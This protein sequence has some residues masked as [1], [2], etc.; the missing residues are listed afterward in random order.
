MPA[1][2]VGGA[3]VAEL[4]QAEGGQAGRIALVAHHHDHP[5]GVGDLGDAVGRGRVEAPLEH[6][7]VDH[8][9]AVE[10]AVPG[11]LLDGADVDDQGPLVP[12][13]RQLGRGGTVG[14]LP[15]DVV[16][17]PVDAGPRPAGAGHAADTAS[18]ASSAP[19]SPRSVRAGVRRWGS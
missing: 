19:M 18:S 7:A 8:H 9:G 1:G 16:E 10:P 13:R 6:V 5:V 15:A 11:T 14:E 4:L 17:H 3:V 2:E 12:Q